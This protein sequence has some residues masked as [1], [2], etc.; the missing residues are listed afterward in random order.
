MSTWTP[1]TKEQNDTQHKR[2][3]NR[4]RWFLHCL[5]SLQFGTKQLRSVGS[6]I[7]MVYGTMDG[8]DE[9]PELMNRP[10][11]LQSL[12]SQM[13]MEE[14]GCHYANVLT[15]IFLFEASLQEHSKST[16]SALPMQFTKF[17]RVIVQNEITGSHAIHMPNYWGRC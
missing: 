11:R 15:L 7:A 12:S 10:K 16:L 9:P 8:G 14:I 3:Q 6:N 1:N 2:T 4:N 5:W 17:R 13:Q